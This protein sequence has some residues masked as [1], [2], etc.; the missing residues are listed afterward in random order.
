[1]TSSSHPSALNRLRSAAM[2][3]ATWVRAVA[4]GLPFHTASTSASTETTLP[5]C[6]KSI[7]RMVR[8]R[9]PPIGTARPCAVTESGPRILK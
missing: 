5:G 7:A 2:Q 8:C 9:E 1:M 3:I 4:G 6:S